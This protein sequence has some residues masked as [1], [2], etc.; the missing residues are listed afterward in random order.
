MF[1]HLKRIES[2]SAI[3]Q[4]RPKPHP[5]VKNIGEEQI[6]DKTKAQSALPQ[7]EEKE[8]TIPMANWPSMVNR[9]MNMVICFPLTVGRLQLRQGKKDQ[10][11]PKYENA[12]YIY[13]S[14][15]AADTLAVLGA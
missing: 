15:G 10:R 4:P 5:E 9:I 12:F 8:S 1:Y 14:G 3:M 2:P 6:A 11:N 7:L 13:R